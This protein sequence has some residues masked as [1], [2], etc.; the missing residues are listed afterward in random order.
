LVL[1]RGKSEPNH[2]KWLANAADTEGWK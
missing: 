2:L 1:R